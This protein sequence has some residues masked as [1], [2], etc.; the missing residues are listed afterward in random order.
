[1]EKGRNLERMARV[2][3]TEMQTSVINGKQRYGRASQLAEAVVA[4][5]S[6]RWDIE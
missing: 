4:L 1:M 2:R 5:K 6:K 3:I